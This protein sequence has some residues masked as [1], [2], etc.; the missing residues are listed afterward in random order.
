M[1]K[2]LSEE[3]VVLLLGLQYSG[4][5]MFGNFVFDGSA[6]DYMPTVGFRETPTEYAKQKL[7]LVEYGGTVV[8]R[9]KIILKNALAYRNNVS[10]VLL[11]VDGSFNEQAIEETRSAYMCLLFYFKELHGVP[12]CVIQHHVSANDAPLLSWGVIKRKLQ[13]GLLLE[14]NYC[15]GNIVVI[16]LVYSEP[17][18]LRKSIYRILD[19]ITK[20]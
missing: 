4:K 2:S 6:S 9:W 10:K 17:H 5:S 3:K 16:R 15:S 13:L 7:L 1:H 18:A 11:F 8:D 20:I 12:L 19:W 14:H